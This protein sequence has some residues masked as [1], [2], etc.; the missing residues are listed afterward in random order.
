[1][2]IVLCPRQESAGKSGKYEVWGGL[3]AIRRGVA[4]ARE[5]STRS[6]NGRPRMFFHSSAQGCPCMSCVRRTAAHVR[7]YKGR[8][9]RGMGPSTIRDKRQAYKYHGHGHKHAPLY[10]NSRLCLST[11][12]GGAVFR[13]GVQEQ[14]IVRVGR[15]VTCPTRVLQVWLFVLF[16]VIV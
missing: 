10:H 9:L 2:L 8:T 13:L 12:L 14:S 15:N 1:M 3:P 6:A 4:H 11:A 16:S 5:H 7:V